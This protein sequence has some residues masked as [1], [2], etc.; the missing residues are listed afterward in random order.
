MFRYG[1]VRSSRCRAFTDLAWICRPVASTAVSVM[2]LNRHLIGTRSRCGALQPDTTSRR[3]GKAPKDH[4]RD[5]SAPSLR[6][7]FDFRP[8][9]Q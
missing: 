5:S 4:K 2:L 1:S 3:L 6:I 7:S 9:S 8:K